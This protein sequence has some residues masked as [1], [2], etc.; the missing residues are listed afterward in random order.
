[1]TAEVHVVEEGLASKWRRSRQLTQIGNGAG[2]AYPDWPLVEDLE[3]EVLTGPI[4]SIRDAVAKLSAVALAFIDGPRG[5][6]ADAVALEQTIRWL[7]GGR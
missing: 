3:L 4:L 7:S 1:M 2:S 5:D 6:E